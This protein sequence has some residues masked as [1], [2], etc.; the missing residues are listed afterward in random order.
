MLSTKETLM[1]TNI[2]KLSALVLA[3]VSAFA[4]VA[5]F[6][7]G[8][9]HELEGKDYVIL[10]TVVVVSGVLLT[11]SITM[12]MEADNESHRDNS[13]VVTNRTHYP[14]LIG[15][16]VILGITVTFLTAMFMPSG[17][18]NAIR[19]AS[20][21][22][23][24]QFYDAPLVNVPPTLTRPDGSPVELKPEMFDIVVVEDIDPASTAT[25]IT[26]VDGNIHVTVVLSKEQAKNGVIVPKDRV[27]RKGEVW[28]QDTSSGRKSWLAPF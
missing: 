14:R 8:N 22:H 26:N 17:L 20:S 28:F 1:K 4:I 13:G 2:Y 18:V 7:T 19:S 3:S 23:A 27:R 6:C 16:L 24:V 11:A 9:T 10:A 12:I 25:T 15:G 21:I 5:I